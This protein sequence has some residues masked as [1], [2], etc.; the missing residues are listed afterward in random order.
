MKIKEA[1]VKA[2]SILKESNKEF[3]MEDSQILLTHVI[4][5][6]KL[7]II[8]NRDFEI[9]EDKAEEY[10]R[11]IDMRRKKMPLRYITKQCEFMGLD[12]HIEEGVLIPR[13]DTEILVEEVL[14]YIEYNNYKK[15]CDVC[16]GS[17]AIG[18]SIAK[19]AN[20]VE[21]LCTDISKDAI[22][23]SEINRKSLEL[24]DRVK[25]EE[26]DLLRKVIERGEKFDVIVSN[27]P[28][29][30]EDEIPTLMEDVKEYEPKIAL[31]GGEDGL[32]FYRKITSMSKEILKPGGLIAYEIGSDEADEVF[33][34][35]KNEGFI[36]VEKRKD[37]AKMDR[38]VLAV[39]GG[40]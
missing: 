17:G 29:I 35:L 2:Y 9:D 8:T 18:L 7:F 31:S 20:N 33:Q 26:G 5:K 34:I 23:V 27:P 15:V 24:E 30:R 10:F 11:Y 6:D 37:L 19:Y 28:Y 4:K 32:E 1:L 36:S 40:L 22:R 12:F 38:V 39:R 3:Y 13:P 25:I 16:S 21:V 14:K